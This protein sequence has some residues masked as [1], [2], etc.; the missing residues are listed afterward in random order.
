[1][2]KIKDEAQVRRELNEKL[3]KSQMAKTFDYSMDDFEIYD[4][5]W[6]HKDWKTWCKGA[7]RYD[8]TK[9]IVERY[10]SE[11]KKPYGTRDLSFVHLV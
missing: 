10:V 6:K 2:K 9:E 5:Q 7:G 11:C 1:M 3:I 8:K 4:S